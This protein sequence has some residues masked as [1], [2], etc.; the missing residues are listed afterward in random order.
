MLMGSMLEQL[1]GWFSL[2]LK[3]LGTSGA[4]LFIESADSGLKQ[5]LLFLSRLCPR[6]RAGW[7]PVTRP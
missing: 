3:R 6:L 7:T 4:L 5:R 2:E 1:G